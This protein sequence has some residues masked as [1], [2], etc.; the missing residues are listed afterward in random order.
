MARAIPV[1]HPGDTWREAAAAAELPL[2]VARSARLRRQPRG[3]GEPVL[4]APGFGAGDASTALLRGYLARLGYTVSG[5]GLGRNTGDVAVLLPQLVSL[6]E[7]MHR[8]HGQPVRLVGWSLGGYLVR[9]VARERPA[10]VRQVITLG[11]PVVGGPKYTTVGH[12]YRR[13][14]ID[15]DQ[16]ERIVDARGAVPIRVPITAIYSKADRIVAWQAC[17]DERSPNVEHVEVRST[18]LGLGISADV[19]EVVAQA[20][21][22]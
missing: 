9:E 21:A 14:G 17:I 15:V 3:H 22:R 11:S 4:V 16:V 19:F 18:H 5:W 2:L 10:L 6:V 20:L 8:E 1:P 12:A 13:Q 7:E